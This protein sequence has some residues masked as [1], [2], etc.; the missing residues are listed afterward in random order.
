MSPPW[1]TSAGFPCPA[2]GERAWSGLIGGGGV[3]VEGG[4][5]GCFRLEE[6]E[7]KENAPAAPRTRPA[8]AAMPRCTIEADI[9]GEVRNGSKSVAIR[10]FR[11]TSRVQTISCIA[12]KARSSGMHN[13]R[14]ES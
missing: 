8:D 5:G 12:H 7:E 4:G 10:F 11:S 3:E 13:K 6:E 14:G 1:Y 9:V 2:S